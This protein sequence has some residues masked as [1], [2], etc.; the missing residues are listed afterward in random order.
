MSCVCFDVISNFFFFGAVNIMN[1]KTIIFAAGLA[2]FG[3]AFAFALG[4][5]E[6]LQA[7][8]H[9]TT[10]FASALSVFTDVRLNPITAF[11]TVDDVDLG[12]G[13]QLPLLWVLLTVVSGILMLYGGIGSFFKL[14]PMLRKTVAADQSFDQCVFSSSEFAH[15]NHRGRANVANKKPATIK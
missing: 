11:G 15:F 10:T 7:A 5:K 9:S 4:M 3:I 13:R 1:V 2:L 14:T 12:A 6:Q 8:H